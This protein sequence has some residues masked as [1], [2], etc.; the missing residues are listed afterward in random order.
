MVRRA[1]GCPSPG[2][3]WRSCAPTTPSPSTSRPPSPMSDPPTRMSSWSPI[4]EAEK[5]L[6][7][8]RATLYRWIRDGFITA[9]QI[10]PGAPWRIRIDQAL[11]DKIQPE[12]PKGWLSLDN[13]AKALGPFSAL[14]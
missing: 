8:S 14:V 10:T 1:P 11:R 4:T 2:H 3:A 5:T 12:A 6:G 7:V 13:A 9:E